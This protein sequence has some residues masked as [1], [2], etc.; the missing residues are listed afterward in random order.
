MHGQS[1]RAEKQSR[2]QLPADEARLQFLLPSWIMSYGRES[3]R[4]GDHF[5][6]SGGSL[7]VYFRVFI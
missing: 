5:E 3:E 1:F 4:E 6:F 7:V 2:I